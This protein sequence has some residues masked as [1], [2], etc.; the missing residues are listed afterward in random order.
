MN[1]NLIHQVIHSIK[2]RFDY[3][4]FQ[5]HRQQKNKLASVQFI[6]DQYYFMNNFSWF[7][8]NNDSLLKVSFGT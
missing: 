3:F 1:T 5:R 2:V 7:E 4:N 8:W 6:A